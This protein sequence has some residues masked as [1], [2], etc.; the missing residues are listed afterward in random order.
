MT[1]KWLNHKYHQLHKLSNKVSSDEGSLHSL[2][3]C[4]YFFGFTFLNQT[5]SLV[6]TCMILLKPEG[7]IQIRNNKPN[8][9]IIKQIRKRADT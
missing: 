1:S 7:E 8:Y 4:H 5:K 3:A 9:Q 2:T 6:L